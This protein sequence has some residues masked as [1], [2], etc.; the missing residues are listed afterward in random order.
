MMG[1]VRAEWARKGLHLATIC[2][3]IAVYFLPES[4]WR[5]P[6]L[7]LALCVL[8]FD[9]VRLG[10]PR[11]RTFFGQMLGPYLR[12]HESEE[13]MGSTYLTLA[14]VL[15]AWIFA[16]PIAVA[17]MGYLILGDGLA[18][19]VGKSWGR[20]GLLFGKTIE[21]TLAGL[22]ANLCVG[23]L[24]FRSPQEMIL[25]ACVASAVE[26]LPVPLDD[27]FAIPVI[28]GV[29]LHLAMT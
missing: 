17:V 12:S 5:W 18:G 25:G 2:I 9:L 1:G 19:L 29:V 21:G 16:R 14:C 7:G 27:N 15:S 23:A 26:L 20:H 24:V 8:V 10:H 22:V 28:S 4:V 3:P 11:L 13:L 6:L